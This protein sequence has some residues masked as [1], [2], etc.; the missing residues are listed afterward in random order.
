MRTPAHYSVLGAA[1]GGAVKFPGR[2]NAFRVAGA[3]GNAAPLLQGWI[4]LSRSRRHLRVD[5][6]CV[7]ENRQ[8]A[9]SK[10][11]TIILTESQLLTLQTPITHPGNNSSERKEVAVTPTGIFFRIAEFSTFPAWYLGLMP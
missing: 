9:A 2:G 8:L 11:S 10:H 7:S 3:G 6:P 1:Q 4:S 5:A